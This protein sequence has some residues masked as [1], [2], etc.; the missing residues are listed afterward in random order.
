MIDLLATIPRFRVINTDQFVFTRS[1][2]PIIEVADFVNF[3][4]FRMN[5]LGYPAQIDE[6]HVQTLLNTDIATSRRFI[7]ELSDYSKLNYD[8]HSLV[9]QARNNGL[10]VEKHLRAKDIIPPYGEPHIK[11]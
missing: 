1:K 10:N 11:P 5:D 6:E 4:I 7:E 3:V 2:E 8:I 9:V